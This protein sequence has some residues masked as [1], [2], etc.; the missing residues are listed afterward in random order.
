M[1]G[2][3]RIELDYFCE[4]S[5]IPLPESKALEILG[6]KKQKHD[7]FGLLIY[8]G[9]G[10]YHR[11]FYTD[12]RRF[13]FLLLSSEVALNSVKFLKNLGLEPFAEQLTVQYLLDKFSNKKKTLKSVLLDQGVIAGLGNIYVSEILWHAKLS[14][15][16]LAASL[17]FSKEK[18]TL[19]RLILSTQEILQK[20]IEAGGSSLRDHRQVS[21]ELGYFQHQFLVYN[22]EGEACSICGEKI[23]RVRQNGRSS[24]YCPICQI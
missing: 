12:P 3:W 2:S 5:S 22:R 8:A 1:S 9:A 24:Y 23:I 20:A 18:E 21:G 4:K 7:H 19:L 6:E 13:G 10:R 14:P 15:F 11:V 16:R 17:A